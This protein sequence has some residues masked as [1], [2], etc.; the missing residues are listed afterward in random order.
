LTNNF[1]LN[2]EAD[3][4]RGDFGYP[5]SRQIMTNAGSRNSRVMAGI[6]TNKNVLPS[7]CTCNNDM[8]QGPNHHNLVAA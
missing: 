5:Q 6:T 4:M 3:S 2:P 8:M 1:H 7:S